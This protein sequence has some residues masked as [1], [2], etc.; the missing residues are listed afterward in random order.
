[1]EIVHDMEIDG[2]NHKIPSL[3]IQPLI[4]NAIIHGISASEGTGKI[5]VDFFNRQTHM[6]IVVRDNGVGFNGHNVNSSKSHSSIGLSVINDRLTL[7][8]DY[9]KFAF[10]LKFSILYEDKENMRGTKASL[11][12]PLIST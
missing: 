2:A 9:Y 6:E 7:M 10:H 12:L 8:K 4:E 11:T 1:Y 5:E 3:M